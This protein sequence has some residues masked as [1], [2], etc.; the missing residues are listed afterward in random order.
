MFLVVGE[1]KGIDK[2]T[3]V[4]Q[5]PKRKHGKVSKWKKLTGTCEKDS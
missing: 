3:E 1:R 2:P 5:A 4:S